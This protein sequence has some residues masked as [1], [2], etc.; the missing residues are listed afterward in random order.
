MPD[1][2]WTPDMSVGCAALDADHRALLGLVRRLDAAVRG[3]EPFEVVGSLLTVGLELT[4]AHAVREEG[5]NRRLGQPVDPAHRHAHG[6]FVTWAEAV[7]AEYVAARDNGRLRAVLPVMFD[8]WHQHVLDLDMAD[9]PFYEDNA[10]RIADLVRGQTM[11]EPILG[12]QP[13]CW[14]ANPARI[15]GLTWVEQQL[16]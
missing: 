2:L 12:N 15:L 5:L 11:A 8:W 6:A 10:E 13:L 4:R 14:P 3:Q 1:L 7:R 9:K 16:C